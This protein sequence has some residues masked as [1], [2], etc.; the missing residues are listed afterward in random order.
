MVHSTFRRGQIPGG[1]LADAFADDY[2][3]Q[4]SE[5]LQ[6]LVRSICEEAAGEYPDGW[7]RRPV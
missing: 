2:L 5:S 3:M 6:P 4:A 1:M 7:K